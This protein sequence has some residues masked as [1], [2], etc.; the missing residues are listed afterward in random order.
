MGKKS[1]VLVGIDIGTTKTTAIVGEV[2]DTGIDIIGIGTS[3]AKELR[4]GVVVNIESTVEAI[5]KAVEEAE[6]MSGCRINSAYVG[7]AGSHIKGQNSL[8]IVAVKGREVGDDDV[9]R[10]IEASKAIAIPVDREILHT[11]PQNYV[12]DGQDGIRD[13][14]G[15]SG[16]RLEAKVHIVTGAAASIQNIVK[17]VNRVGLDIE[18]IVLEQL[19]ASEAV[20][21]S[22]EKDLGVAMID[23]GG[24]N[25]GIAIFS[26]G[27][28]KHTAILPVGGNYLTSDIATG[29]RTPF[30]EAEKIKIKYGCALT[31]MIPKDETIEVPGVGGRDAREV[32]RQILGRIIEPRMEEILNMVSKEVVRSGF[33]DLLAAGV[34]VTGGTSLLAGINELAEQIFDMPVRRGMP[35]GVG[36]LADVVNSPAYATGVGLIFYGSKQLAGNSVY[37]KT[38]NIFSNVTGL[39]KKWFVE[40]F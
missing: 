28:I 39:I 32:S 36:G 25:T 38:G 24:S 20:L 31:A 19:A 16:V 18:D 7:I 33:E 23:I 37:R 29:L 1:N 12:V 30:N 22:D 34:V 35:T 27:S 10:A 2:T 13:P 40:F 5:K 17:S 21:S 8:G 14:V 9:Q 26:E 6:H 3:P 4:K 15:M 11:L